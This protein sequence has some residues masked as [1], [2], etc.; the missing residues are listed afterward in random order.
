MDVG[1]ADRAHRHGTRPPPPSPNLDIDWAAIYSK[2]PEGSLDRLSVKIMNIVL[3]DRQLTLVQEIHDMVV[4]FGKMP[5]YQEY[6]LVA[7]CLLHKSR[8]S[9]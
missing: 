2:I 4:H 3:E 9:K 8:P 6:L 1:N 5:Q 7:L